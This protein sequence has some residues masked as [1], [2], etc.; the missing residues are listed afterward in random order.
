MISYYAGLALVVLVYQSIWFV[1]SVVVKKNDVADIAWGTGFVLLAWASFVMYGQFSTSGF[2][3]TFLVT[4]WG[5]RLALHIYHRNKG[6]PE[7]YRYG[8]WRA[9][10]GKWFYVRSYFQV[11]MLQGIL[12][13]LIALPVILINAAGTTLGP[14]EVMGTAVWFLGFM[15]EYI[16]DRQLMRFKQNP[17]NKCKLMMSG[18]WAYTRHPNYFGEVLGWWGIW[19]VA[20]PSPNGL[21]SVIGPLTIT[22]LIL[23]VS[24]IP[25][26][27]KR[28][29]SHPDF[30]GYK[31]RVPVFF[32]WFPREKISSP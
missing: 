8:A 11:F 29:A 26:L 4:V 18:L 3:V 21:V 17:A 12:L 23:F 10:W 14:L 1:A 2:L 32:P 19:L 5:L 28:M 6:K 13:Y 30:E 25:L 27:E 24:G 7:D 31:K 20:L 22:I 16:G 15:F 9:M